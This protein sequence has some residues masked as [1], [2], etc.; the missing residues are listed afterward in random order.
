MDSRNRNID[1]S[2]FRKSAGWCEPQLLILWWPYYKWM[3]IKMIF[4]SIFIIT[5]AAIGVFFYFFYKYICKL[6]KI[7]EK[8]WLVVKIHY[9]I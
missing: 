9:W 6:R 5:M 7:F 8:N 3:V 2:R 4:K 1:R